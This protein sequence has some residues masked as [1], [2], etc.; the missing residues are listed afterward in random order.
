[1]NGAATQVQKMSMS[2]FPY[3]SSKTRPSAAWTA[4][5]P[6]NKTRGRPSLSV[7]L[8]LVFGEQVVKREL[9]AVRF[10]PDNG[11]HDLIKSAPQRGLHEPRRERL[12]FTLFRQKR[13]SQAFRS[14]QERT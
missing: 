5:D 2:I 8:A 1:M 10:S 13:A 9:R 7:F 11:F 4:H 6:D 14:R 3:G 12:R